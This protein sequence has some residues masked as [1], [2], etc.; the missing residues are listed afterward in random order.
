MRL[1]NGAAQDHSKRSLHIASHRL[2][3]KECKLL[4]VLRVWGR[5]KFVR[6][7]VICLGPGDGKIQTSEQ[8]G[9][10]FT[11]A[12]YQHGQG[13]FPSWATATHSRT[14]GRI[15][16]CRTGKLDVLLAAGSANVNE[17]DRC[18]VLYSFRDR[19][20]HRFRALTPQ[21]IDDD[22]DPR[23]ARR[24]APKCPGRIASSIQTEESSRGIPTPTA[25]KKRVTTLFGHFAPKWRPGLN[26]APLRLAPPLPPTGQ[27]L[28]VSRS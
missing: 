11:F 27:P 3:A 17:A 19:H 2:E 20:N 4:G 21:V 16:K 7:D 26:R 28:G 24:R 6:E 15:P 13:V 22:V 10:R 9:Q 14:G 25:F 1:C 12:P 23:S 8:L 5:V 18:A